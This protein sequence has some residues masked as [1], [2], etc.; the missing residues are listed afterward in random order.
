MN[1]HPITVAYNVRDSVDGFALVVLVRVPDVEVWVQSGC[2]NFEQWSLALP[3]TF[4]VF[5]G[6]PLLLFVFMDNLL[7]FFAI[8][9][10]TFNHLNLHFQPE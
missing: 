6:Q 2:A 8:F 4:D 7:D 1:S 3:Y 5:M 9:A 10:K